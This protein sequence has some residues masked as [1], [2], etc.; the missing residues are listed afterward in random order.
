LESEQGEVTLLLGELKHGHRDAEAK[1]FPLVYDELRRLAAHYMRGER[2]GHSL[3]A[4]ALVHEAYLRLTRIN[5]VDWQGRSHFFAVA[6]QAMRRIL[7]DHAR[8]RCAD[9][10]GGPQEKIS[11]DEA[12]VISFDRPELFIA[13]D[14]ALNRFAEVYPRAARVVDLRFFGGLKEEEAAA[15]LGVSVKTV[16]RDWEFA[17]A[18]LLKDL[19]G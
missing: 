11:L 3:Q 9:R 7:V 5:D 6:A 12:L 10:R 19:G 8:A 15:V 2:P 13:L 4:T 18:W 17:K 14:D 1:L 16:K